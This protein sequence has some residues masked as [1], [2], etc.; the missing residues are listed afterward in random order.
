MANFN[1]DDYHFLHYSS[2]VIKKYDD[3]FDEIDKMIKSKIDLPKNIMIHDLTALP[4][5]LIVEY[6]LYLDINGK[7]IERGRLEVELKYGEID[8][9]LNGLEE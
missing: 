3:L 6:T 8:E 1:R 9:W 2:E 7:T 5:Y 4:E